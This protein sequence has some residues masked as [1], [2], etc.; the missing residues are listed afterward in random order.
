[1][2]AQQSDPLASIP[3][4]R[5]AGSGATDG[6]RA[7]AVGG[8]AELRGRCSMRIS[9]KRNFENG[10]G[11]RCS[12]CRAS[13][14]AGKSQRAGTA[15]PSSVPQGRDQTPSGFGLIRGWPFHQGVESNWAPS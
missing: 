14:R 2:V 10:S 15:Q 1:M 13:A 4:L 3:F 5:N 7:G 11:G 9:R 12:R 8:V 6:A